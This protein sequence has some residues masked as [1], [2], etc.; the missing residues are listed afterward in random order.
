[1]SSK[2]PVGVSAGHP[3]GAMRPGAIEYMLLVGISLAWGTSYM[4]TKVAVAEVPPVTLVASRL[5]I[6]AVVVITYARLRAIPWPSRK[7]TALLAIVGLLSN[8]APLTLIAIS[9]SYVASSVT[10]ITM[11]LVPLITLWLGVFAGSRPDLRS[12]IG[13]ALGFFGV[14]V[15]FGPDAFLS[16]GGAT[17]GLV[18]AVVG[19]VVFSVSLFVSRSVR[20]IHPVMV[21]AMSLGMAMLWS[22]LFALGLDGV[23][24]NAPSLPVLGSIGILAVWNTAAASLMMF[25]LLG[26]ATPEFT[27]YNNHLVPAVAVICGTVFLREPLKLATVI[28][29]CLVLSGV[30]VST[31]RRRLPRQTTPPA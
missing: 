25:A 31:M 23:P 13:I 19:A 29:V 21:T 17:W 9:V 26:R 18:A 12:L 1:M 15:L 8:A 22:L 11:A 2:E 27:S 7:E 5:V 4:F 10:A 6:A 24:R 14:A 16:V 3:A 20:H 30:A 28:G